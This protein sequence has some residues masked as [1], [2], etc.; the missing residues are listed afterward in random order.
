VA[1]GIWSRFQSLIFGGAIGA[2]ASDAIAPALEPARQH[3][4][5]Q[6]QV[7]ILDP[8]TLAALVAE[9][10]ITL[11]AA[12]ATATRHGLNAATFNGYVQLALHGPGLG[13]ALRSYQRRNSA[14]V[15]AGIT[16]DQLHHAY[17][18]AGIEH[19]Y[20]AALDGLAT[21]P[22]E[23][24]VIAN[25]IVRGIID[26]PF[27]LPYTPATA[28]GKVQPFPKSTLNATQESLASGVAVDR[29]FVLTAIA[30]R[31]MAPEEAAQAVF[32]GII[33]K[34]DYDRAI[35]EGD[36]RSEY[37]DAIFDYS[38]Q[39]STAHD[40][41]ENYLRGYSAQQD[42]YD[43]AARHGMSVDD[44]NIIFENAGRPLA[45]HQ[46]TTG[47][48]RGASF[49]PETNEQRDPY[50]ASVRE[51]NIKPS[52]Y[53]LAI[54]NRY[55]YPALFQLNALVKANAISADTARDWAYKEGYAPE[56]LD[57]LHAF[58]AGEQAGS[59]GAGGTKPKQFTYS[60]IHQAWRHGVLSDAQ[61]S[62]EL[63]TLGY[64]DAHVAVLLATWK[65]TTAAGT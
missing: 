2:A 36:I 13:E 19:Q 25:A 20:W 22:L 47:L 59:S 65:A 7:R 42:M 10:A 16:V 63:S 11:A 53:D 18:K 23:P 55:S 27:A 1:L 29:L 31:P 51:S 54:A 34:A 21:E 17:A 64:S 41:V 38:R 43:R 52:Y 45:L 9:G 61:A 50:Q 15:S 35:A 26:A 14:E 39:I 44:V 28:A 4:W 60:Q 12:Q 24:A 33:D 62:S 48:A 58:W 8:G 5:Q 46:I 37:R 32:R 56:V 3:A 57:S 40:A 49:N 6:N 30:G